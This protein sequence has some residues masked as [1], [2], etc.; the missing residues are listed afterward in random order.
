MNSARAEHCALTIGD[1][2]IVFGG[3]NGTILSSIECANVNGSWPKMGELC[4]KRF[5]LQFIFN[6]V[7][8]VIYAITIKEGNL[9]N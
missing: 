3:D 9:P 8:H 4:H 5:C 6:F 2:I 7:T 1:E